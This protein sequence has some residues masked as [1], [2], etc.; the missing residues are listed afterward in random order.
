[1]VHWGCLAFC[2]RRYM[3]SFKFGVSLKAFMKIL[4][5][6]KFLPKTISFVIWKDT[7]TFKKCSI[8]KSKSARNNVDFPLWNWKVK[9]VL[10]SLDAKAQKNIPLNVITSEPRDLANYICLVKISNLGKYLVLIT[11]KNLQLHN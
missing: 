3:M 9:I 5:K 11:T 8:K 1:M 7:L 10:H 6:E 2:I 4:N